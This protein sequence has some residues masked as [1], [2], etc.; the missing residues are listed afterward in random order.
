MPATI[1][2][3]VISVSTLLVATI[4][5][6]CSGG[7]AE[8]SSSQQ[9][10]DSQSI[11]GGAG[12][13]DRIDGMVVIAERDGKTVLD[14]WFTNRMTIDTI[15]QVASSNDFTALDSC[16]NMPAQ[17]VQPTKTD[18]L[19]DIDTTISV[20]SR[21]GALITLEKHATGATMV[22]ASTDRWLDD[23]LPDD[24]ILTLS[25]NE[26]FSVLDPVVVP[27]LPGLQWL[28]PES[29]F[30]QTASAPLRWEPSDDER[31]TIKLH[32]SR[33]Q[34]HSDGRLSAID[35]YCVVSDDGEF[36]L[37]ADMQDRLEQS[38]DSMLIVYP[39]RE[40]LQRAQSGNAQLTVVQL[41]YPAAVKP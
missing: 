24:A 3:K 1:C 31:S 16:S 12:I 20:S 15:S 23:P 5:Y 7:G 38:A 41:A 19:I 17:A 13:A 36:V 35:V 4:L 33:V 21:S 6:G 22:Y 34:R 8:S 28:E 27:A 11:S 29:G 14:G 32:L 2:K 26:L 40:L 39:T 25:G 30:M 18:S 9:D 10:A 37:P